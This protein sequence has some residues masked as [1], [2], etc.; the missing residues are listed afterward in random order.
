[1]RF[2]TVAVLFSLIGCGSMKL[3]PE[4]A[5]V[6]QN[7]YLDLRANWVK[8]K[9]KKFDIEMAVTNK[10]DA[11]LIFQLRDMQCSR[12]PVTGQLQHTFFNTGE[13]TIDFRKGQTKVFRFV[14]DLG[15]WQDED[16][17]LVISKIY[18]NPSGD[19]ANKGKEVGGPVEWVATP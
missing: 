11:D 13:R 9:S 14:C 6:T 18:D 16:V 8:N 15:G 5:K 1:M 10:S 17:K 3:N 4:N 12:G 19:G 2:L 7:K